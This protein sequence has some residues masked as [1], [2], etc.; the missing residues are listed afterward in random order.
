[1]IFV[2]NFIIEIQFQCTSRI[3]FFFNGNR[4]VKIIFNREVK[5]IFYGYTFMYFR[6]ELK[7][8]FKKYLGILNQ[9]VFDKNLKTDCQG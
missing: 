3:I 9:K 5:F 7:L 2:I 1:M 8:N 6:K 4:G